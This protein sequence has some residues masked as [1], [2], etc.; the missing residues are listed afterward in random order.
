MATLEEIDA[1]KAQDLSN[2]IWTKSFASTS[3]QG[4]GDCLEITR[5]NGGVVLRNSVDPDNMTFLTTSEW[6]AARVAVK[7]DQPEFLA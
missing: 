3:G 2:N 7:E 5:V 1:L 6:A 4:G